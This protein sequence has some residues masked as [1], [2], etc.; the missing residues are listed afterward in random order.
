MAI[1]NA[2]PAARAALLDESCTSG[3]YYRGTAVELI[4]AGL[5]TLDMFPGQPGRP[6]TRAVFKANDVTIEK[7]GKRFLIQREVDD[8]ERHCREERE[9]RDRAATDAADAANRTLGDLPKSAQEYASRR[10]DAVELFAK[11]L[12][13]AVR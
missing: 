13:G 8:A 10:L 7:R 6:K 4:A 9:S 5:A 12:H 11:C 2:A 3:D 1:A